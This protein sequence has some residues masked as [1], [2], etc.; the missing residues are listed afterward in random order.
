MV[1][2]GSLVQG[3]TTAL[4]LDLD[5]RLLQTDVPQIAGRL[6][7]ISLWLLQ[8]LRFGGGGLPRLLQLR[9]A[10]ATFIPQHGCVGGVEVLWV[11]GAADALGLRQLDVYLR[12]RSL[13]VVVDGLITCLRADMHGVAGLERSLD[14]L[15]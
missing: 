13:I 7:L 9:L 12:V 11:A 4:A 1:L 3:Q 14:L 6:R 2:L 10:L 8:R 15:L 5:I